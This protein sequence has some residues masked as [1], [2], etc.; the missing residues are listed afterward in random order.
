[1]HGGMFY[2]W[3]FLFFTAFLNAYDT[4]DFLSVDCLLEDVGYDFFALAHYYAVN[5]VAVGNFLAFKLPGAEAAHD[6]SWLVSA[7]ALVF[8]ELSEF[9]GVHWFSAAYDRGGGF[10]DVS[11]SRG[12]HAGYAYGFRV[13]PYEAVEVLRV[14]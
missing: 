14:D 12:V 9:Y 8:D 5:A 10:A 6:D 1:M 7:N 2:C 11:P 4:G 3:D 13:R